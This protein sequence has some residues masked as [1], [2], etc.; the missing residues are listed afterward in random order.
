MIA[1]D[2]TKY[3]EIG[4]RVRALP[5]ETSKPDYKWEELVRKLCESNDTRLRDI[6][7]YELG[8]LQEKF[9]DSSVCNSK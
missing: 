4:R 6:G 5:S 2:R 8:V 3:S 9:T 7:K 1:I